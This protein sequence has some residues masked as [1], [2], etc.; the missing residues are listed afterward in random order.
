MFRINIAF[1]FMIA[2]LSV[3]NGM[4]NPLSTPAADSV[5]ENNAEI[6]SSIKGER[7]VQEYSPGSVTTKE[8]RDAT[9]LSTSNDDGTLTVTKFN[10]HGFKQTLGNLFGITTRRLRH[11]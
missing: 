8:E 5:T 7:D 3:K 11:V 4:G 1:V 10:G 6:V 2:L 9:P